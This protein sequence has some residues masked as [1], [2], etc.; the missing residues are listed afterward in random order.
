ME[1]LLPLLPI[2]LRQFVALEVGN[3]N[4]VGLVLLDTRGAGIILH[5]V[6]IVWAG[7]VLR[8]LREYSLGGGGIYSYLQV[9]AAGQFVHWG[10]LSQHLGGG[11]GADGIAL[12]GVTWHWGDLVALSYAT[13]G[14]WL[15]SIA[16]VADKLLVI[17]FVAEEI[18][19]AR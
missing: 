3:R 1:L 12:G 6:D 11:D 7:R 16:W 10:R 2:D 18:F 9:V 4:H 14:T 8:V 5:L 13:G 19:T 17:F 15:G